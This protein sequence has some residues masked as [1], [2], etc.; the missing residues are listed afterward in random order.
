MRE[1]V[2]FGGGHADHGAREVLDC[3]TAPEGA[4]RDDGGFGG[5][6]AVAVCGGDFEAGVRGVHGEVA[7]GVSVWGLV[8]CVALEG[9]LNW[10]GFWF[11][12]GGGA[13]GGGVVLNKVGLGVGTLIRNFI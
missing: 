3:V 12:G 6:R 9:V 8:S 1:R 7:A 4:A 2:F 11:E 5:E 10:G 13:E